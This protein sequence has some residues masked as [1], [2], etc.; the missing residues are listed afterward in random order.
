MK[1]AEK[2]IRRIFVAVFMGIYQQDF[3]RVRFLGRIV[4]GYPLFAAG[5]AAELFILHI[6]KVNELIVN[7]D[8]TADMTE[9]G[10]KVGV[11]GYRLYRR[12]VIGYKELKMPSKAHFSLSE[13]NTFALYDFLPF[14]AV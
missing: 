14:P 3:H 10:S 4:K 5:A 2:Q 11:L 1:R 12:F 13:R 9:K 7:A 6:E 8:L